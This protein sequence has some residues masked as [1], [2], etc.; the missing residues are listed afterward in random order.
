MPEVEPGVQLS[1]LDRGLTIHV[2]NGQGQK[3]FWFVI[4]PTDRPRGYEDRP[5]YTREDGRA[6]CDG[7]RDKQLGAG[8]RFGAIWARC[9]VFTMTALEEGHFETWGRGRM[10]CIGDAVRK[11]C[12]P[13]A[14]RVR[15]ERRG[16]DGDGRGRTRTTR[17]TLYARR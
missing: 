8:V 15:G 16:A 14:V 12:P 10:L 13:M 6:V 2:F 5:T 7:L 9:D 4:V 3:A 1:L 11:A 17:L